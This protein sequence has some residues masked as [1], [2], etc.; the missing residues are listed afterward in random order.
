LRSQWK[1]PRLVD[2]DE[3]HWRT[4]YLGTMELTHRLVP[5]LCSSGRRGGDAR[6]VNVVSMLHAKG[7]N[8]ALFAPLSPYDSWTAYGTSKLALVHATFELDRR[9][10]SSHVRATCLHP[11]AVYSRIAD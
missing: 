3:I 9:M 5:F 11:G 2:G 6:I 7:R 4:N 1:A 10:A 8:D